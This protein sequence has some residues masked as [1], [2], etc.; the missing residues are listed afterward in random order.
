MGGGG[1][2]GGCAFANAVGALTEKE[3]YYLAIPTERSRVAVTGRMRDIRGLHRND[4][5]AAAKTNRLL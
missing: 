3:S 2:W 4:F 1:Q 5:V